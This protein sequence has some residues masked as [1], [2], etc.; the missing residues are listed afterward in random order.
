MF[1]PLAFKQ[2]QLVTDGLVLY[3]DAA[4]RTSYVSGST[5]WRSLSGGVTGSLING[6]TFDTGNGGSIVFDGTND[7]VS[8]L[9]TIVNTP[10]SI[11]CFFKITNINNYNSFYS[12]DTYQIW[13]GT[14]A[15]TRSIIVH[16]NNSS[17]LETPN[18]VYTSNNLT[19]LGISSS[20]SQLSIFINDTKYNVTPGPNP[21]S[22]TTAKIGSYFDGTKDFFS[23]NIA[24]MLMY[25]KALSDQQILQNFNA[26]RQRFNI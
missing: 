2:P 22:G 23:G 13:I 26:Q 4:D 9:P 18:N 8:L 19:F 24:T 14:N 17:R 7:Y 16:T 15:G 10:W 25:N 12:Q 11:S 5:V 1:T 3:L 20:P 6:P 21:T